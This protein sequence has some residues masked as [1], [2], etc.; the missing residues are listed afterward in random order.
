MTPEHND[1]LEHSEYVEPSQPELITERLTLRHLREADIPDIVESCRDPQMIRYTRVPLNYT[2]AD[3]EDSLLTTAR[4][5]AAGQI[6]RWAID[7][8]GMFA[9]SIELR[10][11]EGTTTPVTLALPGRH[12]VL[13]ALAAAAIGWQLGVAP[14]TIA[15]ALENFAGIGRRF[16]DL[17]EVTTAS[18]ARVRVVDDYGHHPREL[19]AVFAAA[20]GGWPDK[21]LVVAFQPHR[22]SRTRDQFDAFAAVLSTVDAL[23]LSEVYPAGEAPIPGADSRALA[24]AIRARGRSEPVVVGQVAGLSEV[25]P[26]VLQDGDLLLMMGAGDIGY[27]A[28]QIV[29]D[30]FVGAPA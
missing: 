26:D 4:Q 12:N 13:N 7:A 18:G 17:G 15:R 9:G 21:R 23:V 28:Q 16:N 24:R 8:S 22:Y 6:Q 25:L 5:I 14:D 10:L 2:R 27:V 20:R 1:F 30:G 11:P 29:T 19:E 3:A